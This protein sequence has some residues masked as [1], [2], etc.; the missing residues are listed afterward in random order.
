MRPNGPLTIDGSPQSGYSLA[1]LAR[2]GFRASKPFLFGFFWDYK[3]SRDIRKKN[4]G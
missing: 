4:E 1:Q 3:T 2:F